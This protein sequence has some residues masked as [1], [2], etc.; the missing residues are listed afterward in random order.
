MKNSHAIGIGAE[1]VDMLPSFMI[2]RNLVNIAFHLR[3]PLKRFPIQGHL[4]PL[5]ATLLTFIWILIQIAELSQ[6]LAGKVTIQNLKRPRKVIQTGLPGIGWPGLL[7]S[8]WNN[9]G[10]MRKDLL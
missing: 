6:M 4:V 9:V 1:V 7:R 8:R 3:D 2:G 5:A 10:I